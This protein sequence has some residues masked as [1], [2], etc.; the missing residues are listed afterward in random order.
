MKNEKKEEKKFKIV[1]K[2]IEQFGGGSIEQMSVNSDLNQLGIGNL[3]I[4]EL[5]MFIEEEFAVDLPPEAY[6]QIRTIGDILEY[7]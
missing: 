3:D 6:Q 7:V 5:L 4:T 1:A 2:I